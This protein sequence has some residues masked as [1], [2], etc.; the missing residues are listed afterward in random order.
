M[1]MTSRTTVKTF[2]ITWSVHSGIRQN[3]NEL[4]VKGKEPAIVHGYD[5]MEAGDSRSNKVLDKTMRQYAP[6][7]LTN[8]NKSS[9]GTSFSSVSSFHRQ[10]LWKDTKELASP[11]I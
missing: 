9:L 4:R 11:L 5:R 1:I 8:P 6:Q 2:W 10:L 3:R 7:H